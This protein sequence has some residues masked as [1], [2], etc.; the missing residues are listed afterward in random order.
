VDVDRLELSLEVGPYG[1]TRALPELAS[2]DTFTSVAPAPVASL[3]GVVVL[4]LVPGVS[5]RLGG[6]LLPLWI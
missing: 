6:A 1:G 5:S 2:L 3:R 4:G